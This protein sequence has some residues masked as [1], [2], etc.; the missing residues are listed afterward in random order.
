MNAWRTAACL[1]A[2]TVA[3][4]AHAA[5]RALTELPPVPADAVH[6]APPAPDAIPDT[7]LGAMIRFGRDVFTDTQRYAKG[8]VG[9]GLNCVNCH[10]DAGRLANAAPLWAAYVAYPSF[11]TKNDKV[12]TFAQRLQGCF[13]FS[14]NGKAPP[15]D[16]AVIVGLTSYAFWLATGAPVGASLA[17]RGYPP[18]PQ[19][20][21]A[22]DVARGAAAYRTHCA[23]CH[24][25][26]GGGVKSGKAYTFPPLWGRDSY[27]AGAGMHRISTAA[28]FIK[29][30]MPLG[31]GNTLT[32]QEVWDLAAF[33]NSKPRPPDP[34][35]LKVRMP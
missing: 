32:D 24:G 20:P 14:M 12:N 22:P 21:E 10:L 31:M 5:N 15:A 6:F 9:N 18:V 1:A 13:R 8:Y 2:L 26:N 11:R 3:G 4:F 34:G 28:A 27:N 17:G 23:A 30:N 7:P 16:S 29:A 35:T 25:A 19:P 33:V